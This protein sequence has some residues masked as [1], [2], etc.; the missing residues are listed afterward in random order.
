MLKLQTQNQ[1]FEKAFAKPALKSSK[2]DSFSV[3]S[4]SDDDSASVEIERFN[5]KTRIGIFQRKNNM[6]LLKLKGLSCNALIHEEGNELN[7]KI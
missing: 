2:N 3:N 6:K 1:L 5:P 4:L 7:T